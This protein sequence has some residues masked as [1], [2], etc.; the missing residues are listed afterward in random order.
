VGLSHD[1]SCPIAAAAATKA[2]MT[3]ASTDFVII[4]MTTTMTIT[5]AIS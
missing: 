2:T 3:T 1:G 5:A 4:A